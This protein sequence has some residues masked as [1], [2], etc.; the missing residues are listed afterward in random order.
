MAASMHTLAMGTSRI[1][2]PVFT[3]FHRISKLNKQ[4]FCDVGD[5]KDAKTKQVCAV[6]I[7]F[8]YLYSTA[9]QWLDVFMPSNS[10]IYMRTNLVVCRSSSKTVFGN[11]TNGHS[12]HWK[13][14]WR[15]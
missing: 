8:M 5:E 9:C 12:S 14:H 7:F 4:H 11:P 3:R 1:L 10:R 13:L 6:R 2:L 15:N